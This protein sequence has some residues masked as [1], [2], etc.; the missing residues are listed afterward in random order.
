MRS[1]SLNDA[2]ETYYP[3]KIDW[4][5]SKYIGIDL[6]WDYGKRTVTLSMK[7]YAK[8]ALQQYIYAWNSTQTL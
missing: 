5:G 3:L 1:T 4:T 8:K 6:T 2:L 7:D